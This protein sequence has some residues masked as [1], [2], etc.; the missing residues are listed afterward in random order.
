[1][2]TAYDV[3]RQAR[4]Q[5]KASTSW[6]IEQLVTHFHEFHG[7]REHGD[8][9]AIIGGVGFL[10][11]QAVT[12]IG[13]NKG[14]TLA[15][16]QAC[17]FGCATP[18]GYRKAIRLMRQAAK[19]HRPVL[20]LINTPGA[21]PGVE[22]EYHGQGDAIAQCIL[23]GVSLPVPTISVIVGEAGSGGALALACGDQTWMFAQSTYSILSPEGYASILWRD[24][25]RAAEAAAQ[26]RLTPAEILADGIVDRIVPEVTDA[27]GASGLRAELIATMTELTALPT[28]QLMNARHRRYR[29]FGTDG[30]QEQ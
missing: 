28:Q 30:L 2:S 24:G 3:V 27:A 26:M 16:S 10:G 4:S 23:T 15:E 21:Y 25:Q 29:S 19:F 8:D 13:T 5:D 9:P 12:V 22:A 17:H 6:L 20:N 1:M 14:R 11:D 18:E 7:D